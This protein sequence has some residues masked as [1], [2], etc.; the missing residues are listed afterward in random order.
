LFFFCQ[1]TTG[2]I[3]IATYTFVYNTDVFII[4]RLIAIYWI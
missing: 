2:Y 3:T 1:H 4:L